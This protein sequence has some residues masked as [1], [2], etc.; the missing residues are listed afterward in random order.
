MFAKIFAFA[1]CLFG[2][3]QAGALYTGVGAYA[4]ATSYVSRIDN[5]GAWNGINGAWNGINGAWNGYNGAWNGINGVTNPGVLG[6]YGY[7][8]YNGW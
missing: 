2:L 1:V 4:P 5:N 8:A 7:G 3:A 6:G